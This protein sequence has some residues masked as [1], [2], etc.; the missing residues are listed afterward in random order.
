VKSDTTRFS[1]PRSS[2]RI[3]QGTSE[4]ATQYPTFRLEMSVY[5]AHAKNGVLVDEVKAVGDE[6]GE[7]VGVQHHYDAYYGG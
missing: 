4:Y 5:R 7:D 1:F 6:L 2:P 3:S